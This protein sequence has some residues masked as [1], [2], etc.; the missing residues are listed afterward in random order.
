M[1]QERWRELGSLNES[2]EKIYI[3]VQESNTASYNNMLRRDYSYLFGPG[4]TVRLVKFL[5]L[6]AAI[7]LPLSLKLF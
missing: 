7:S 3:D 6:Q 2:L 4:G 5:I 1:F